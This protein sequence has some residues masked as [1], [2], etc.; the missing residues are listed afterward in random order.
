[1][2]WFVCNVSELHQT[3]ISENSLLENDQLEDSHC[4]VNESKQVFAFS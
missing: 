3:E 4:G 2:K 1:M